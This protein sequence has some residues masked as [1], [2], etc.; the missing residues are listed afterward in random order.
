MDTSF[1]H[2]GVQYKLPLEGCLLLESLIL[3]VQNTLVTFHIY[4]SYNIVCIG[5]LSIV[6]MQAG[7][8]YRGA[9]W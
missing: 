4:T 2:I 1:Y 8:A 7:Q 3:S 9:A 6:H 5:S